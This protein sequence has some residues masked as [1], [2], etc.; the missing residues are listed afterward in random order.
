MLS[1]KNPVEISCSSPVRGCCF[2][3]VFETGCLQIESAQDITF[4]L[5]EGVDIAER[6][7]LPPPPSPRRGP[8]P[9]SPTV[10]QPILQERVWSTDA[11]ITGL[12]EAGRA[13]GEAGHFA[14]QRVTPT[15]FRLLAASILIVLI[16]CLCVCCASC[17]RQLLEYISSKTYSPGVR[18]TALHM[19]IRERLVEKDFAATL[20]SQSGTS[21]RSTHTTDRSVILYASLACPYKDGLGL[22]AEELKFVLNGSR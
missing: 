1:P 22:S 10:S 13:E 11:N 21:P 6:Y 20:D 3:V 12:S 16:S 2:H 17:A 14:T 15:S 8:A 7:S 4:K 19:L 18:G 9:Q 5:L